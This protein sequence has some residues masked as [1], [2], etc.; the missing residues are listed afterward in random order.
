[1]IGNPRSPLLHYGLAV[2]GARIDIAST[3][4]AAQDPCS[5]LQ[6]RKNNQIMTIE[7][8]PA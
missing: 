1:V 3:A 2:V 4:C 6:Y 5:A 7:G 8:V